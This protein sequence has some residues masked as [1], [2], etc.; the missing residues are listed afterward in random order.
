MP[1]RCYPIARLE[2]RDHQVIGV[3]QGALLEAAALI[4][5][6]GRILRMDREGHLAV[7]M[8][9]CGGERRAHQWLAVSLMLALRKERDPQLRRV[10][11]HVAQPHA[12]PDEAH[13]A[14][15]RDLV[16]VVFRDHADIAG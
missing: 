15:A 2:S 4:E 12:I 7:S 3:A 1:L 10:V 6:D 14:G 11:I 8:L 9:A 16:G 5:P 13:P